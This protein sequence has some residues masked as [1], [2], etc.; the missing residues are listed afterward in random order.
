MR[1]GGMLVSK[2]GGT[3]NAKALREEDT[4]REGQ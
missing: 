2:A 4:S 3:A 1:E